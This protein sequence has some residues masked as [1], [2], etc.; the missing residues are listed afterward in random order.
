MADEHEEN[1]D[2]QN[3]GANERQNNA[4]QKYKLDL[5]ID[6]IEKQ[7]ISFLDFDK[8]A[9]KIS[10]A[11]EILKT[12]SEEL[13]YKFKELEEQLGVEE[14]A[15]KKENISLDSSPFKRMFELLDEMISILV[16]N[17]QWHHI[18]ITMAEVYAGKLEIALK[19]TRA[20]SLT[21]QVVDKMLEFLKIEEQN[22]WNRYSQMHETE[23]KA[24]SKYINDAVE[25]S[26]FDKDTITKL[27]EIFERYNIKM[28]SW[29][30]RLSQLPISRATSEDEVDDYESHEAPSDKLG[31]DTNEVIDKEKAQSTP[32][33]LNEQKQLECN[34]CHKTFVLQSFYDKHIKEHKDVKN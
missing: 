1:D 18:R 25:R 3:E 5:L 17:Q 4:P 30:K 16:L 27:T 10:G 15:L 26:K 28:T 8:Y 24:M 2:E 34:I 6:E 14:K 22:L 21:Q 32:S 7:K 19:E 9:D 33:N 20:F 23:I 31:T 29:E 13:K 12:Q 11:R